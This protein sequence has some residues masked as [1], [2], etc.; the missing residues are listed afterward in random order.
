MDLASQILQQ[1]RDHGIAGYNA[2]RSFCGLAKATTFRDYLDVMSQQ[3]VD[4]LK[5]V[6]KCVTQKL[7]SLFEHST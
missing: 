5:S 3:S 6:Y 1:G 2:W 7:F 4:A